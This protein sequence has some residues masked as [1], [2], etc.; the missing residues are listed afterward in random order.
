MDKEIKSYVEGTCKMLFIM[1]LQ[2]PKLAISSVTKK[3]NSELEDE[4]CQHLEKRRHKSLR[5][6]I[7]ITVALR[8]ISDL[9]PGSSHPRSDNLCDYNI[10]QSGHF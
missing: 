4:I 9:F 6:T 2:N 3:Q 1:A 10:L 8:L 5:M 7:R